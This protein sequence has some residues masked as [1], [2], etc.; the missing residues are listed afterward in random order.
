[1]FSEEPK[2]RVLLKR[3]AQSFEEDRINESSLDSHKT[4]SFEEREEDYVRARARIFNQDSNSSTEGCFES[5]ANDSYARPWSSADSGC[6]VAWPQISQQVS[7]NQ[8]LPKIAAGGAIPSANCTVM[9][10]TA[11]Y[12]M[13]PTT[14]TQIRR[15]RTENDGTESHQVLP[16]VIRSNS[17]NDSVSMPSG[18]RPPPGLSAGQSVIF[19]VANIEQVPFGAIIINPQTGQP[20]LNQDGTVYRH[21]PA[22]LQFVQ[23]MSCPSAAATPNACSVMPCVQQ[24]NGSQDSSMFVSAVQP[25]AQH[26]SDIA[27]TTDAARLTGS[28]NSYN[29]VPQIF[30]Y[31]ML[32][33]QGSSYSWQQLSSSQIND[34][35][36]PNC[37]P[38]H[39]TGQPMHCVN[40]PRQVVSISNQ[41]ISSSDSSQLN[42]SPN[43][44]LVYPVYCPPSALH[45]NDVIENYTGS[46]VARVT[47]GRA[48]CWRR[49]RKVGH[50]NLLIAFCQPGAKQHNNG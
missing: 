34:T 20:F 46:V 18:C 19:A 49:L 2:H 40:S 17:V 35:L 5:P 23:G 3:D 27:N 48:G 41:L 25:L 11:F 8:F 44:P 31:V 38:C 13:E 50:Q 32:Q 21:N 29:S 12:R 37:N 45:G 36:T 4:R 30:A 7:T 47:K 42:P 14:K 24:S 26:P 1:M 39:T 15:C 33:P 28:P 9:N 43:S 6:D 16:P 10:S 22:L